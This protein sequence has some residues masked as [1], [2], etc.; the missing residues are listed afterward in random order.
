[1]NMRRNALA[2]TA[3]GLTALLVGCAG[4]SAGTNADTPVRSPVAQGP[5][6]TP[7]SPGG[8]PSATTQPASASPAAPSSQSAE[9][10]APT[11]KP[12]TKAPT[13]APT[14]NLCGAPPNPYGYNFCGG[15][16]ISN[17]PGDIC[18]Y[19]DCIDNFWNGKGYIEQ[20]QDGMF[21]KSGGIQGSCS[22]HGGNR[23]P[24]N[25]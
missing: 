17:P 15:A 4:T 5:S 8:Q 6:A 13:K 2:A 24:L 9:P 3:A 1:M 21:G 18:D 16:T 23:R 19:L 25:K 14:K 20:C 10:A 22:H 7:S 11:T 12:P